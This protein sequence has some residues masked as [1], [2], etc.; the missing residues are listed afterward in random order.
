M[1]LFEGGCMGYTYWNH[2]HERERK[3][4]EREREGNDRDQRCPVVAQRQT[5][6]VQ[7][8]QGLIIARTHGLLITNNPP[9]SL[10]PATVRRPSPRATQIVPAMP[11]LV[12]VDVSVTDRRLRLV[13]SDRA[14]ASAYDAYLRAQDLRPHQL[15]TIPGY[16]ALPQYNPAA[17]AVTLS[18]PDFITWFITCRLPDDEDAVTFTFSDEH[19]VRATRWVD[20]LLL[21]EPV[22]GSAPEECTIPSRPSSASPGS[23]PPP[24]PTATAA[25][26]S[27]SRRRSS[28]PSS[29]RARRDTRPVLQLHVRRLW[30][31]AYLLRRLE[32]LR[33]QAVHATTLAV[34]NAAM[35][36]TGFVAPPAPAPPPAAAASVTPTKNRS[37]VGSPVWSPGGRMPVGLAVSGGMMQ[38]GDIWW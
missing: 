32:D 17:R 31:R 27:Y 24:L 22:P 8:L 30:N 36:G 20:S 14:V 13:F 34:A 11:N 1:G 33:R 21:L 19:A 16:R 6:F 29:P 5:R 37:R 10:V 26:A 18:L 35:A 28:P 3:E 15:Q 12:A 9:Y 2:Q 38:R 23:P 7:S 25:A 4:R